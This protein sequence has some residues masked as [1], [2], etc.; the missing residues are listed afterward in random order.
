[1]SYVSPMS[2]ESLNARI[3]KRVDIAPGLL[4]L[5]VKPDQGFKPFSPGQYVAL[6]LPG[7]HPRPS[8]YPPEPSPVPA[9]KMIKRSYSIGS[10]PDEQEYLE[11]YIAIVPTGA[12]TSRL[13]LLGEGDKLWCAPKIVGTFVT[14]DVPADKNLVLVATGTGLAPFI[15][16]IKSKQ[17]WTAQRKISIVHGVRYSR[18]FAYRDELIELGSSNQRLNYFPIVSRKDDQWKG[19]F[20]YVQSLFE[21]KKVAA[22]P[23]SD[24]VFICG[25]PA[26]VDDLTTLLASRGYTEHSRKSPGTLHLEKYW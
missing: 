22:D 19:D 26:M 8:E 12:F 23:S 2:K 20:G 16:M 11:F 14:E 21:N 10:A 1:M 4:I 18:D 5:R 17:I 24:H 25:N 7:S 3:I 9:D 13:Q 15:S 6:G